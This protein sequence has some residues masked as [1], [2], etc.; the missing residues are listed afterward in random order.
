MC[1]FACVI[2]NVDL[3]L[4]LNVD[5][6][7]TEAWWH[8]LIGLCLVLKSLKEQSYFSLI[9]AIWLHIVY[10]NDQNDN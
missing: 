9:C 10:A 7:G 3:N 2:E 1:L 5:A 4:L 6:G 8:D